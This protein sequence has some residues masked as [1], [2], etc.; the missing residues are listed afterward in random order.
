MSKHFTDK[1]LRAKASLKGRPLT[2]DISCDSCGYNLRGLRY[3]QSCPE[4]GAPILWQDRKDIALHEMPVRVIKRF[5]LSC[6][7][8]S[9][10]GVVLLAT[11]VAVLFLEIS[12]T[13]VT[14]ALWASVIIWAIATWGLTSVI[15]GPQARHAGVGSESKMRRC[16]RWL[17]LAWLLFALAVAGLAP[18]PLYGVMLYGGCFGGLAGLLAFLFAG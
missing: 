17:N 11:T 5:R 16:A 13:V 1:Y 4:C 8:A 14:L 9:L 15:E 7:L 12:M 18:D 6:R 3:G 10:S 2:G